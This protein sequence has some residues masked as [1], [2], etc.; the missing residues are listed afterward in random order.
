TARPHPDR[1]SSMPGHGPV[2]PTV[3]AGAAGWRNPDR[4]TAGLPGTQD[5][6]DAVPAY[7]PVA[8]PR[9]ESGW[10]RRPTRYGAGKTPA[11]VPA[12]PAVSAAPPARGAGPDRR[13][14]R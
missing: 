11:H 3:P 1:C 10:T 7:R 14:D 4:N 6:A 13:H 12:R 9:P 8:S 2:P 5:Q